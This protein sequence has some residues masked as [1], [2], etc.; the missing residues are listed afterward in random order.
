MSISTCK[1]SLIV[2][3][4]AELVSTAHTFLA[5]DTTCVINYYQSTFIMLV[6][7]GGWLPGN[8]VIYGLLLSNHTLYKNY[9]K[10]NG[11]R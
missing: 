4:F 7:K 10:L 3:G 6:T 5:I 2:F 8:K 9:A 1:F 11:Q